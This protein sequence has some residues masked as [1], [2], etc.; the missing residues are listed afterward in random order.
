MNPASILPLL[1]LAS[2]ATACQR[3]QAPTKGHESGAAEAPSDADSAP[4]PEGAELTYACA[5]GEL[6]VVYAGGAARVT[7]PDGR[8]LAL[9][10]APRPDAT[11]QHFYESNG[12][13]LRLEADRL[14]LLHQGGKTLDCI[15]TSS[16]H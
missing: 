16:T 8:E 1:L 14:K 3:D 15:E 6:R 11:G 12:N 4:P 10:H 2:L 13:V 7:L 9:A 5:D